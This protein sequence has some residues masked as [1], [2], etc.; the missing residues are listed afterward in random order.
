MMSKFWLVIPEWMER[1]VLGAPLRP[2]PISNLALSLWHRW[3]PE[4]VFMLLTAYIDESGTHDSSDYMIMGGFVGRLGQ[5]YAVDKVWKKLL[6]KYNLTHFHAVDMRHG[7]GEFR[8]WDN[9]KK[10]DLGLA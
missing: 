8:G 2:T 10:F 7:N 4:R 6:K 5:W 1:F 3:E 9:S